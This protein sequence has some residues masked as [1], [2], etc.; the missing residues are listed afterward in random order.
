[1]DF[2]GSDRSLR[3]VDDQSVHV[4]RDG[5]EE[6]N[7]REQLHCCGGIRGVGREGDELHQ[8][9]RQ[10]VFIAPPPISEATTTETPDTGRET[11]P[12]CLMDV[13]SYFPV[14]RLEL[15][16]SARCWNHDG[17]Y[18]WFSRGLEGYPS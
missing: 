11:R 14:N 16:S 1:M 4:G 12:W 7:D 9:S 13:R 17:F 2:Y 6:G 5:G 10:A 18:P 15:M 8:N 3:G